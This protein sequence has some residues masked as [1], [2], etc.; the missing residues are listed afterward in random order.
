MSGRDA[1]LGLLM[2]EA[3]RDR[4]AQEIVASLEPSMRLLIA[5]VTAGNMAGV[6]ETEEEADTYANT[7]AEGMLS[8]Q[9]SW[10]FSWQGIDQKDLDIISV[11]VFSALVGNVFSNRIE[12]LAASARE[13]GQG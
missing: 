4:L 3:G 13:R 2:T 10:F 6:W 11:K 1:K 12:A 5:H 8:N 9:L 7:L